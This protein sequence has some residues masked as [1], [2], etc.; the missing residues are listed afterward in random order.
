MGARSILLMVMAEVGAGLAAGEA[1]A[2]PGP[3]PG[4]AYPAYVL[5]SL[6]NGSPL[7]IARFRGRKVLLLQFAS[8]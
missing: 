2:E 7:S 3:A 5:P 1:L 4:E 6:E 8:W